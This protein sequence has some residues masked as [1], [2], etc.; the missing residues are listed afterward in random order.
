[1]NHSI[2]K[3]MTFSAT[4]PTGGAGMQADILTLSSLGCHPV[5]VTTGITVQ[6]TIGV[7]SMMALGADWIVDQ[8]RSILEDMQVSAFKCGLL[9]SAEN[10]AAVA[11]IVSDYPEIPLIIDPVLAS[12]RGDDLV[13]AAMIQAMI[14]LLFPHAYLITPNSYEARRLVIHDDEEFIDLTLHECAARLRLMGC[15]NVLITGTHEQTDSVINTLYSA[16]GK[17]LPYHWERLPGTFHGSG[18]TLASSITAFLARGIKLEQA[19]E[20]GQNF[21]WQTL[22]HSIKPGMGQFIPNRFFWMN[23]EDENEDGQTH[24]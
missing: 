15:K 1:M 24:H 5:S 4:D 19:V 2:P 10:M 23:E 7:D 14:E 22:K 9:G 8:A 18:C 20:E 13:D 3:V 16:S 6:D 17:Q 12:G 21:T 11:E